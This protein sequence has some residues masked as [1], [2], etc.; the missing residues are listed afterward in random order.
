[1]AEINVIK[2]R[3]WDSHEGKSV[4]VREYRALLGDE[5]SVARCQG[6]L[7]RDGLSSNEQCA[8][9]GRLLE[10]QH[11]PDDER[12]YHFCGTH[13]PSRI[14]ERADRRYEK[15]LAATDARIAQRNR[16]DRLVAARRATLKSLRNLSAD[17]RDGLPA[18]VRDAL[19]E[20]DAADGAMS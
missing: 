11:N 16:F 8:A 20:L 17:E 15:Q 4:V 10:R 19:T 6:S 7:S 12:P 18:P 3:R 14:K 2:I 1:M 13:A 5:Q 9:P